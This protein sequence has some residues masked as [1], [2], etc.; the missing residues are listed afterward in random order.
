M[1][2]QWVEIFFRPQRRQYQ[3]FLIGGQPEPEA[4]LTP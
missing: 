2:D 4:L 3:F 1:F